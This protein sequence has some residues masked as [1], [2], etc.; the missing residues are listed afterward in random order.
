MTDATV[1]DNGFAADGKTPIYAIHGHPLMVRAVDFNALFAKSPPGSALEPVQ[2]SAGGQNHDSEWWQPWPNATTPAQN[3][4]VA[5]EPS[6]RE[7]AMAMMLVRMISSAHRHCAPDSEAFRLAEESWAWMNA[8]GL[9]G[10]LLRDTEKG[11]SLEQQSTR[12]IVEQVG[13][14]PDGQ[15]DPH[16][17][18]PMPPRIKA[19]EIAA[20]QFGAFEDNDGSDADLCFAAQEMFLAWLIAQGRT[21]Q[22][23]EQPMPRLNEQD[24]GLLEQGASLLEQVSHDERGRGNDAAAMGADCSAHAV[25]RLGARLLHAQAARVA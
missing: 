22:S 17:R 12:E 20:S 9:H 11:P 6:I 5:V 18:V 19:R 8:H 4:L 3:K 15:E 21:D 16:G 1:K 24:A 25:R 7:R 10:S 13:V 2:P 14:R 23:W